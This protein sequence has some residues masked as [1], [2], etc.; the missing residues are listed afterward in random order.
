MEVVNRNSSK[1]AGG[2]LR[3]LGE[4][5]Q[6]DLVL[7]GAG[8]AHVQVLRRWMMSPVPGVRLTLV[9]DRPDAVYSGMVPGF[10]AGAYRAHE[11]EIDAVPLARR[12][13]ARVVLAAAT[14]LDP[15]AHKLSIE[16]RP[17]LAYDVVSF[18]VGSTVR[19][20]DLPGVRELALATRPISAFVDGLDE[21]LAADGDRPRTLALVGGGAAGVE[22]AFTLDTRAGA[23]ASRTDVVLVTDAETILPG[24]SSA[25]RRRAERA[26]EARGIRVKTR[27]RVRE[28]HDAGIVLD[29]GAELRADRVVWVT[30]AAPPVVVANLGL[31]TTESGFLRVA[32]TLQV[33]GH[34]DVFAVGDCA[35]PDAHPWIPRAGVYAVRQGPVLDRNL[36]ARLAGEGLQAY[37][38]QR[39]FLALLTLGGGR[40]LGGKWGIAFEGRWVFRLK[41]WIDRRFME[42]FK[43]LGPDGADAP[44][45][46]TPE[47][48]GMEEMACGGCAAKV[49]A[50]G[51]ARVLERLGPAT[52]DPRV[53]VGLDAPDDAAAFETR[54]KD[55]LL[56][57]VDGFRAFT[58]DPWLVGRVAAQNAASDVDA[59]GGRARHALAWVTVP[60][61]P[62]AEEALYQVMA[63]IRC[64]LDAREVSL[65]GGHSTVGPELMV[66]LAVLGELAAEH[67]PLSKAGLVPGDRLILTKALGSGVALAADMQG[68][69]RGRDLLAVHT[70]M[71]RGNGRAAAVARARGARA[72]TDVSGFGLVVHLGEMLEASGVGAEID[73]GRVPVLPGAS[74]ALKR[75]IR[76]TFHPQNAAAS[77]RIWGAAVDADAPGPAVLVDP[78]TSG[79]L[80]IG[81]ASEEAAAL[82][83]ALEAGGDIDASDIG[84]VIEHSGI[85]PRLVL[86]D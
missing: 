52:R 46:P 20:L 67:A 50:G 69:L 21:F 7:V 48:M 2:L 37:R 34:D 54:S 31:P 77:A 75:G 74:G 55:V 41:D 3:T 26:L 66:G 11:L 70:A 23:L 73:P 12:A 85:G 79:G 61:G 45:F 22:L 62:G 4:L 33:V 10:A 65:L 57:T 71:L 81:V 17:T 63:G 39:D 8:H 36:R 68:R 49:G 76:S 16:G 1:S 84:E 80:L 53:Q 43:V 82:V 24:A 25:L 9:V 60:E 15:A 44:G 51:L 42:R 27:E 19:G 83:D 72:M 35:V 32:D 86:R 6:R 40:A 18:D 56:A 5:P 47:S 64:E 28:V 14:G 38:P 29:S 58:D 78:Q 13:G 30:G 59:T